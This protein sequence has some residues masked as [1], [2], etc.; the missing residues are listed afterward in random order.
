MKT[1]CILYVVI[2]DKKPELISQSNRSLRS[3]KS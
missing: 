1:P 3:Y 2:D